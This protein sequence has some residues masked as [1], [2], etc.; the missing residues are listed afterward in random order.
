MK[1]FLHYITI[2]TLLFLSSNINTMKKEKEPIP[3]YL[4]SPRGETK[5]ELILQ[6]IESFEKAELIFNEAIEV[7]PLSFQGSKY[8]VAEQ[9]YYMANN[10]Y[11]AAAEKNYP[12]A[13][14]LALNVKERIHEI[15][16]KKLELSPEF[17]SL[18][19]GFIK[20]LRRT[21]RAF[22]FSGDSKE[23]ISWQQLLSETSL[24]NIK[25]DLSKQEKESINKQKQKEKEIKLKYDNKKS[26]KVY[27]KK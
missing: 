25:K 8:Q 26:K 21:E 15:E 9:Y 2:I 6:A 3:D 4:E 20:S 18:S 23:M 22:T 17:Y 10:Y 14:T 16:R 27:F 11:V 13:S 5:E 19:Q 1:K 24:F 12:G 7:E